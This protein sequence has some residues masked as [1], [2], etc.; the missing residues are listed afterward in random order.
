MRAR[1]GLEGSALQKCHI[2]EIKQGIHIHVFEI[3]FD[4]YGGSVLLLFCCC[5]FGFFFVF[6]CCF[7]NMAGFADFK[8]RTLA[9]QILLNLTIIKLI[10]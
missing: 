9:E 2:W 8:M 7:F 4:F 1:L 10:K 3:L 5:W 6:C